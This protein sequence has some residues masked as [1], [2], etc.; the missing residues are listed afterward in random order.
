MLR[1]AAV[2]AA[3]AVTA[4]LNYAWDRLVW[5]EDLQRAVMVALYKGEDLKTPEQLPYDIANVCACQDVREGTGH[6]TCLGER[7]GVLSDL[8]GGFREGRGTE[9]Q[10][11]VLNEI[12]AHRRSAEA[13]PSS[14]LLMSGKRTT[15]CG[16]R[17]YGAS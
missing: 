16:G 15:E 4:V 7:T 6:H 12:V 2:G 3:V 13:P 5:P 10:I 9:D 17:G 8:Q 11:F 1:N 14:P